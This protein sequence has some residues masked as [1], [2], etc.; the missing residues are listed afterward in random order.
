MQTSQGISVHQAGSPQSP[1]YFNLLRGLVVLLGERH[2][3]EESA[4][5]ILETAGL[6]DFS[7]RFEKF[8]VVRYLCQQW[9]KLTSGNKV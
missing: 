3:M 9:A 6:A 8:G 1:S 4:R 5:K 2:S 7:E